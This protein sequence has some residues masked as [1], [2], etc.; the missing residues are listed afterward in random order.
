M[1]TAADQLTSFV[2]D[3]L[4]RGV[5]RGDITRELAAAGWSEREATLALDAFAESSLPVPVPRKRV[6]SSARDAFLHIVAMVALFNVALASGS[7]LFILIERWLPLPIDEHWNGYWKSSL[8]WG[9]AHIMVSL[10][11]LWCAQRVINRDVARNPVSRLTPVYRFL[12]Y[13]A[14]LVMALVMLGDLV[15]VVFSLLQEMP[16]RGSS[17][18]PSWCWQWPAWSRSGTRVTCAARSRWRAMRAG[19]SRR[20]PRGAAGSAVAVWP[21]P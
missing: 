20:P 13:L 7:I 9:V 18:R 2:R 5:A 3:C 12:A 1:A 16:H 14:V 15:Y 11:V 8:R 19:R 10:P 17:S 21:R 4:A 6:S